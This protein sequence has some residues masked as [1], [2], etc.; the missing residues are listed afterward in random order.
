MTGA[1]WKIFFG[2]IIFLLLVGGIR[3]WLAPKH[4]QG[5]RGEKEIMLLPE[6]KWESYDRFCKEG[7]KLF[8]QYKWG[9]EKPGKES[10]DPAWG[11]DGLPA[12]GMAEAFQVEL[13]ERQALIAEELQLRRRLIEEEIE[14]RLRQ[15]Q[16]HD[17]YLIRQATEERRRQQTLE[18]A[19]FRRGKEK[20]YARKLANI[21]FK[22]ELPDLAADEKSRLAAEVTALEKELAAVLAGKAEAQRKELEQFVKARQEAA[23]AE[24]EAYRRKLEAEG[25]ERLDR[26]A[27][28]LEEEFNA[29]LQQ[30]GSDQ[31][32]RAETSE[33]K[34]LF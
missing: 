4:T 33:E 20:E 19:D 27:Q 17:D 18:F 14:S 30:S 6:L 12:A 29:W 9:T 26:E 10:S 8:Q 28:K 7:Q 22:L 24:R 5:T 13:A 31:A 1:P 25:R 2:G 23:A 11:K 32:F 3:F 21:R 16:N 15:R 34:V